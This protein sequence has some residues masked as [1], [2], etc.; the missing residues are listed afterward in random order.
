[1]IEFSEIKCF[2]PFNLRYEVSMVH[3]TK[4]VDIFLPIDLLNSS[5][6]L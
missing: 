3:F 6:N 2:R 4:V 1:M 5:L